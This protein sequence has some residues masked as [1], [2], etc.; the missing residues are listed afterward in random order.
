MHILSIQS[1]VV[2][3][4]CEIASILTHSGAALAAAERQAVIQQPITHC[5][6][7]D[8]CFGARDYTLRERTHLR[9]ATS[10]GTLTSTLR[11]QELICHPS[12]LSDAN[13]TA[14][15]HEVE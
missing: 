11:E 2:C 14:W 1:A 3:I 15:S 4:G 9:I 12:Q 6:R 7:L 10:R 13:L 5:T 8:L